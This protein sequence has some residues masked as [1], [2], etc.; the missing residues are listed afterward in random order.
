MILSSLTSIETLLSEECLIIIFF[1]VWCFVFVLFWCDLYFCL[2]FFSRRSLPTI[3]SMHTSGRNC[4]CIFRRCIFVVDCRRW[5][6]SSFHNKQQQT[7]HDDEKQRKQR[8]K[9]T[10]QKLNDHWMQIQII[11][12]FEE[13]SYY[14]YCKD[15]IYAINQLINEAVTPNSLVGSCMEY[16]HE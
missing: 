11:L 10:I 15:R 2:G 6:W 9:T 5:L 12:F 7:T 14:W 3:S 8:E 13:I 4:R 16:D 1:F